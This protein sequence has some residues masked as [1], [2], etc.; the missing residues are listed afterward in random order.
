MNT[1]KEYTQ[2]ISKLQA[3]AIAHFI[4][5]ELRA[6]K[7]V[8]RSKDNNAVT[9]IANREMAGF[10]RAYFRDTRFKE[11]FTNDVSSKYN[12]PTLLVNLPYIFEKALVALSEDLTGITKIVDQPRRHEFIGAYLLD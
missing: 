2:G 8:R 3:I 7:E 4:G 5:V 11:D 9:E 1:A 10:C 12:S 6:I